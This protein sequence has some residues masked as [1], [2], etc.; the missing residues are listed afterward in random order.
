M[1]KVSYI[2]FLF[3]QLLVLIPST[4]LAERFYPQ[5]IL[6]LDN[7]FTHHVFVVEKSTHKLFLIKNNQGVPEIQKEFQIIAQVSL[8]PQYR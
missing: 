6:Q 8:H 4:T 1:T 7:K 5:N 3:A 2:I